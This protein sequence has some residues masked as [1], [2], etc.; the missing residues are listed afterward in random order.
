M[1]RLLYS[2]L[3]LF[4]ALVIIGCNSVIDSN[5]EKT[6][7]VFLGGYH[8]LEITPEGQISTW[9]RNL[10]GQ[11]GD[12]TRN[13][14]LTPVDITSEFNLNAKETIIQAS[15]GHSHSS[16]VTSEGR[17]FTWGNNQYG[18][19]GDGTQII[20]LIPVD[21][22][23]EFNLNAGEKIIEASLSLGGMYSSAITSDGRIF[24]W[25]DNS[26]G[27]LGV[28]TAINR[29]TPVD[30]TSEFN[31]NAGETIIQVSLGSFHSSAVTSEGRIFTWG[32]NQSGQLGD[33]TTTDSGP[34]DVTSEF[35]LNSEE[36]IIETFL[37]SSHSSAITSEGRIFTWGSNSSGQL[38]DGTTTDKSTPVDI[39]SKFN[40]NAKEMII[41]VSLG[42]S[43]SSAITS[44][45]RIFTWGHNFGGKLGDGTTTNR[46]TPV[47]IT[48][49]FNLNAEETIIQV[50]LGF[51]HSSAITSEKR[52]FIWGENEYGQLGDETTTNNFTPV[53]ITS[54]FN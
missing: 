12:G 30:V 45:G 50:S 22:T 47:D 6:S 41:Q 24:T 52:V 31:L 48:S 39:S 26:S 21:I 5:G 11:L 35:N 20:R 38:G 43:H 25:G 18:Q 4:M 28:A 14:K 34:V 54:K 36:M 29:L 49:E 46:L 27:Q 9:G 7:Q 33:G 19:L 10:Y 3:V 44:E 1:K 53:D 15:L 2:A 8:S 13:S 16:A 40:L 23:S 51:F 32:N 37:G 17:I 42:H